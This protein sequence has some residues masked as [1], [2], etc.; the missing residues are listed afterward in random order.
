MRIW[1]GWEIIEA[2]DHL[3]QEAAASLALIRFEAHVLHSLCK[4]ER[5]AVRFNAPRPD[6]WQSFFH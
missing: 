3:V 6:P 1:G 5:S 4:L 2:L